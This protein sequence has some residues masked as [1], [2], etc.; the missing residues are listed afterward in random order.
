MVS[1][2]HVG[3]PLRWVTAVRLISAVPRAPTGSIGGA[4]DIGG[5]TGRM[6]PAPTGSIGGAFEVDRATG[7]MYPAPTV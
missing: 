2:E 6:Y 7:R 3:S 1:G 5:A 4:F